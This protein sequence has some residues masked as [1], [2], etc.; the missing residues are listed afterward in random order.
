M[1]SD[2]PSALSLF[3][4]PPSPARA[5]AATHT[6][7]MRQY[8]AAKAEVPGTL[9]FY[10]MGDFYELFYEDA[11][12]AARLLDIALT[13]R[14]HSNGEPIP[15]AGI[16]AATVDSYL[17]KL[18]RLGESVAI[19]E[20][21]GEAGKTKGPMQRKIVRC[22]TPGTV[23]DDSLL[24]ARRSTLVASAFR[25]HRFGLAWLELSSG[26]FSVTECDSETALLAQLARLQPA[27]ILVA[28]GG[29][30][31]HLREAKKRAPWHFELSVAVRLLTHQFAVRDLKGFG[32]DQWPDAITAA[33]GLLQYVQETQRQALPHLTGLTT[34]WPEQAI[35][36]DAA[37]Y[38]NLELEHSLNQRE[39]A[40]L[41]GV[42]D[43]TQTAMGA[44][45]CRRWLSRP[46]R[47][48]SCL[49][50]R[51][52][53]ISELLN[54]PRNALT[55]EL[56]GIGD[57]ERILARIALK[58]AR[59]R[60]LTQCR[61][62]LPLIGHL[63]QKIAGFHS[64]LIRT[65][66]AN[67]DEHPT[68]H[69]LLSKA[70]VA[71]PPHHWRD[72][73]VI[74]S[75]YDAE[76]DEY[77]AL[78]QHSDNFLLE[79]EQRERLRT[80]LTGLKIA[81][82]RVSGFYIELSRRDAERVPEDY[83]RRQTVKNSERYITAELKEFEDKVLSARERSLARERFLFENLLDRLNDHLASLRQAAHAIATLD[84]L[85]NLANLASDHNYVRPQFSD[86]TGV[87]MRA[88]RHPVVEQLITE[89]FV[90]NDLDLNDERRMIIITG[91]N[92]GG[93]STY[94]RQ[95]ALL[96]ILAHMGSFVPAESF[97]VG[98]I[99]RIF[100][101]IGASD[102]LAGGRSTFMVEM[103][104][105]ANILNNATA[106]SL[107]LMDEIG[108]GTSTYDGLSL[109]FAA[110]AHMANTLR[111]L[112]LFATHYFELTQLAL[113][114]V[115]NAHLDATE[116]EGRLIFMH[117]VKPGP[118]SKSYGLHVA[119]LAG[120]PLSVIH[121]AE[122]YLAQLSQDSSDH[123]RSRPTP[124]TTPLA[125]STDDASPTILQS[126]RLRQTLSDMDP[127]QL[128]PKQ[129]HEWLYKLKAL[130]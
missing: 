68:V 118:A 109:A 32:C 95:V 33:G 123:E 98:P 110:A 35:V 17:A 129:A 76:L 41:I 27:E 45:E 99:D 84:V 3:D 101:R 90:A 60:D 112:T 1:N 67:L 13:A 7:M 122:H 114:R 38:R 120:V 77:R 20:Q 93:K 88:G 23:T 47:D 50:E 100:T 74:A 46:L 126:Q 61:D 18:V 5:P 97:T 29:G 14:G 103:T 8:L 39:D 52:D 49:N 73:G 51:L 9:L 86:D 96:V 2:H 4:D 48:R 127:D 115:A 28:E 130:L 69:A 81:F 59:A 105:T 78:S 31:A 44:R 57:L 6:P 92:M 71:D 87:V 10:R 65:I 26:R 25:G 107:V 15:M 40:T 54:Q 89:P 37:T 104:E 94:M 75:G 116:H 62:S 22:V 34:E 80:G 102:D 113:P 91:P 66:E 30:L 128:T 79:L 53:A 121:E 85:V 63:R 21:I 58:T 124:A 24:D 106:S 83:I 108:R 70:L 125:Q 16:P 43:H 72:G 64:T 19:C 36:I 111:S 42:L 82:N 11:R 55:D 56:A 117:T 12:K 119:K